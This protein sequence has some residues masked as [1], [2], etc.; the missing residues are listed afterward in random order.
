MKSKTNGSCVQFVSQ[1]YLYNPSKAPSLLPR[2]G[3]H[4]RVI[5]AAL[6]GTI[7]KLTMPPST[8][9]L[10][11]LPA[12][13]AIDGVLVHIKD[14]SHKGPEKY[15]HQS[16]TPSALTTCPYL[17]KIPVRLNLY[18]LITYVDH[19]PPVQNPGAGCEFF[20]YTKNNPMVASSIVLFR[21]DSKPLHPKQVQAL[22]KFLWHLQKK[23]TSTNYAAMSQAGGLWGVLPKNLVGDDHS[24]WVWTLEEFWGVYCTMNNFSAFFDQ[25]RY[26]KLIEGD[27]SWRSV[28][29]PYTP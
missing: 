22:W 11:S 3:H 25:L 4:L 7:S 29:S 16:I 27:E 18:L 2:L 26:Q 1:T 8:K 23:F 17:W 6:C 13:M 5:T 24:D 12:F 28:P 21:E 14:S 19:P 15:D 20:F 10:S 9:I